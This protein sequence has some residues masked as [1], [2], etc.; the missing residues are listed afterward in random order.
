[1]A[2]YKYRLIGFGSIFDYYLILY[3][4]YFLLMVLPSF[5]LTKN[6]KKYNF[7]FIMRCIKLFENIIPTSR[8]IHNISRH[9]YKCQ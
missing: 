2:N 9:G 7:L 4:I 8:N 3:I 1:M 6:S 5:I